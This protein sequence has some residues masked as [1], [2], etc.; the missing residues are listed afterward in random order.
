MVLA[1]QVQLASQQ[2][3]LRSLQAELDSHRQTVFQ[4]AEELRSRSELI[5]HMKLMIEKLRHMMFGAKSEKIFI[6][7]GDMETTQ[8][9]M[10]AVVDRVSPVQEKARPERKPLPEHL[11]PDVVTH[12]PERDCCPDCGGQR[13][14]SERMFLSSSSTSP[15][16][17][18]SFAT[19]GRSSPAADAIAWLKGLR[20]HARSNAAWPGRVYWPMSSFRS[21]AIICLCTGSR[22]SMH[23]RASRFRVPRWQAGLA[24]RAI[25]LA[26]W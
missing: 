20:H 9:Q 25:C 5:E 21:S 3:E 8:A 7:L 16:P 11:T 22:R 1:H 24:R 10:E 2:D 19:Y 26:R 15:T 4:Q 13:G 6:Q 17:S 14:S 12:V 23:V 18:R